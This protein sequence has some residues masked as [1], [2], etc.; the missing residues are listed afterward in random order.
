MQRIY[1]YIGLIKPCFFIL[2][3]LPVSWAVSACEAVGGGDGRAQGF[4][5]HLH[6]CP[7]RHHHSMYIEDIYTYIYYIDRSLE[8][9]I[10]KLKDE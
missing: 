8:R 2:F 6:V 9:W 10:D 3:S 4:A 5:P 7:A 1:R